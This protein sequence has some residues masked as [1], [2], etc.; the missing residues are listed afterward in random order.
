MLKCSRRPPVI[1][2]LGFPCMARDP[3]GLFQNQLAQQSPSNPHP[4]VRL[5]PAVKRGTGRQC[6]S[7]AT[8][9]R[10]LGKLTARAQAAQRTATK[11][12]TRKRWMLGNPP[13]GH[14]LVRDPAEDGGPSNKRHASRRCLPFLHPSPQLSS[15][16]F[17]SSPSL[18]FSSSPSHLPSITAN[19]VCHRPEAPKSSA[20]CVS[21]LSKRE[22]RVVAVIDVTLTIFPLFPPSSPTPNHNI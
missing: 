21:R 16:L 22:D 19:S 2:P 10:A 5:P 11:L 4:T 6:A 3:P 12:E 15:L 7:A 17:S 8:H 1:I 18:L 9:H 20:P 13:H 14:T